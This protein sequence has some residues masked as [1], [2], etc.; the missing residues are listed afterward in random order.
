MLE[1]LLERM[2]EDWKRAAPLARTAANLATAS[3]V[4]AGVAIVALAWSLGVL[5]LLALVAALAA[6]AFALLGLGDRP[7]LLVAAGAAALT[8]AVLLAF[9]G[10]PSGRFSAGGVALLALA[11]AGVCGALAGLGPWDRPREVRAEEPPR[12]EPPKLSA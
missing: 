3:A 2:P 9:D 7:R 8:S 11:V 6:G 1:P 5:A 4:A 12:E 10:V